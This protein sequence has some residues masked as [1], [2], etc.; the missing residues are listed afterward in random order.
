MNLWIRVGKLKTGRKL[1]A[2]KK[3]G[4][5][6]G[7]ENSFPGALCEE[8]NRRHV[9]GIEAEFV[10]TG[11]AELERA[12]DYAVVI[13]RIS[14]RVPFYRAWLKHA[15]AN[16]CWVINNPAHCSADDKFLNYTL[17]RGLG[18]AVPETVLLPHKQMP[19]GVGE[20]TL[21]NL[22]YPLNWDRVFDRIGERGYLKPIDGG[23]G[24]GVIEVTSRQSF[25]EAYDWSGSDCMLYQRAVNWESYFRCL[26]VGG[27][28]RVM[29]YDPTR[30]HEE[31]YLKTATEAGRRLLARMKRDAANIC[32][33]IGYECNTVEFAV[34]RGVPYA[35]DFSNPVPDADPRAVGE[36]NFRWMV[37]EMATLAIARARRSDV[38]IVAR[39]GARKKRKNP[40]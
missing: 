22:E 4:L 19:D 37:D 30:P 6:F 40:A 1:Q 35:I 16:G 7:Q 20:R 9:E 33:V 10:L 13:D 28:V 38:Q 3:I 11:A 24:R 21:R 29:P 34:E 25:F 18:I 39:R 23:G 27:K 32:R 26:V 8:V 17:A 12:P 36:E 2:M 31:R 15:A 14:H 5:L